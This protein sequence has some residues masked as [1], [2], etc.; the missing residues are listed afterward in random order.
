VSSKDRVMYRRAILC[1]IFA[2][3]FGVPSVKAADP[4]NHKRL[5]YVGLALY[6][7]AWSENDVVAL[8]DVLQQNADFDVV[9]LIA[10]NMIGSRAHFPVADNATIASLVRNAVSRAGPDDIVVVHISTHGGPGILASRIGNRPTTTISGRGLAANLSALAGHANVV[11]LSACY[12]GSLI[13]ALRAPNRIIITAAR[14][15]RSS[16]GCAAEAQHTFFGTAELE[17]FAEPHRSLKDVFAAIRA[18]VARM[19]R[20][21]DDTPSEP[22][23]FVGAAVKGLYEA[24]V[25]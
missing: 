14:S 3:L 15:D 20:E 24:P 21:E 18:D 23:V 8:S 12:S 22:Q 5:F 11:I 6:S 19:E 7:E 9:P 4:I 1:L 10:S 13:G 25:F 17:G 16:F 2:L